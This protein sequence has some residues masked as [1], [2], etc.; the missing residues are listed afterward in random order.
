MAQIIPFVPCDATP[1]SASASSSEEAQTICEKIRALDQLCPRLL[2]PIGLMVDRVLAVASAFPR[3]Q[4]HRHSP[5]QR[6]R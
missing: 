4:W 1:R 6:V 5:S 2:T 3:S